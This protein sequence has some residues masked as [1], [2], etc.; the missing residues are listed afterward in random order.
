ME[1]LCKILL[2]SFNSFYT[3]HIL[4]C[5][6]CEPLILNMII[7][8]NLRLP[9]LVAALYVFLIPHYLF[10]HSINIL[11]TSLVFFYHVLYKIYFMA[12]KLQFSS[13]NTLCEN[14]HCGTQCH[15][16][17]QPFT[18]SLPTSFLHPC[19]Y[20]SPVETKCLK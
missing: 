8:S 6:F 20:T 17:Y 10:G 18:T 19:H 7:D 3:C 15:T 1:T 9:F 16:E 12:L 5:G 2:N 13:L 4:C 14:A 11:S